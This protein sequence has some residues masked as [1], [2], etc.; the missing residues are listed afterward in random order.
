MTKEKNVQP[1]RSLE[2]IQQM[3]NSL[4]R[5]CSY[6]DYFLFVF[7]I[8]VGLRMSDILPLRVQDIRDKTHIRIKEQKTGKFRTIY[9]N[10]YLRNEIDKYTASMEPENLLFPSRK[11]DGYITLTQAYRTLQ[12]AAEISG[13]KHVGSRTLRKTFG[14]HHYKKYKNLAI[15]QEFFSHS[16]PSITKKYIGVPQDEIEDTLKDFSL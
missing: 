2:E 12:K 7:G 5:Y 14:Y 13:I 15:L 3:K 9:L 6:R 1:I 16:T 8:N 4:I 11:G 10:E